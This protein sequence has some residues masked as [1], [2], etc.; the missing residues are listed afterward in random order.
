MEKVTNSKRTPYVATV[1]GPSVSHDEKNVRDYMHKVTHFG[2][3]HNN[4]LY[5][6]LISRLALQN[7]YNPNLTQRGF[8]PER[9]ARFWL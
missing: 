9:L 8:Q 2:R 1:A 7:M 4:F 3:D 5:Q 6:C